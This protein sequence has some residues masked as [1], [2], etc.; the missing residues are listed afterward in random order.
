MLLEDSLI[1][2]KFDSLTIRGNS[3]QS[4]SRAEMDDQAAWELGR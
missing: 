4:C 1:G 2:W 3:D